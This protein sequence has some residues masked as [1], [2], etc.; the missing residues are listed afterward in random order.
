[1][2]KKAKSATGAGL[3]VIAIGG[4]SLIKNMA[5]K[6]VEDQYQAICETMEHVADLVLRGYRVVITHGNG[7]QVGFI[8]RR[9][10]IARKVEG[11][12]IVPLVSC[13]ADT[14]GALGYQ[15]QQALDNALRRRGE[16][17]AMGK[18][19]TVVTQVEVDPGDPAFDAPSK[20]IGEF[21]MDEQL[22]QLK[23][24][25]PDWILKN[26]ANR[27]WRRVVPSPRPKKIIEKAAISTL[28]AEGFNVVT[29]GGG[30]IPVIRKDG[31]L[32][33]VDAVIDKDYAT[34]LLAAGIG[35]PLMIISTGVRR[36]SLNFG[37]PFE[38]PLATVTVAE[39]K[40]YLAEGHFAPGSMA[41]KVRAAIQFIEDGGREVIITSP[42][43]LEAAVLGQEG[44]HIIP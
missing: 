42:E 31:D 29:V 38:T 43:T 14:Q 7:P 8:M 9:S 25:H 32:Q 18:T 24:Q 34:A 28:V 6:T 2:A 4:N 44:T 13:V 16:T 30:G 41:P 37:T 17:D 22:P 10:E 3:I 39:M 5:H 35:A 36:V 23:R 33:G 15:I 40:Q 27:G 20:P 19:V 11:L 26:D 1:M 21:Y 12:H